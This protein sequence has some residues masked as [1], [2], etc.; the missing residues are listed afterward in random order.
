LEAVSRKGSLSNEDARKVAVNDAVLREEETKKRLHAAQDVVDRLAPSGATHKMVKLR[1]TMLPPEAR[2]D[3]TNLS[4][5]KVILS[6]L[7]RSGTLVLELP[8]TKLVLC[9]SQQFSNPQAFYGAVMWHEESDKAHTWFP[10]FPDGDL[11]PEKKDWHELKKPAILSQEVNPATQNIL[12]LTLTLTLIVGESSD[13]E[14]AREAQAG[15]REQ[16]ESRGT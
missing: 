12:T 5:A 6:P 15:G 2:E 10:Y 7:D 11:V 16:E 3:Q 8:P 1:T 13:T 4:F 14:H 9:R